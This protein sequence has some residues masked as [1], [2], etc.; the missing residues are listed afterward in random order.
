M[1][2]QELR[3]FIDERFLQVRIG[4]R[5]GIGWAWFAS[6]RGNRWMQFPTLNIVA[7]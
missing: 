6:S 7:N 4:Q 5:V 1:I 2:W 3:G